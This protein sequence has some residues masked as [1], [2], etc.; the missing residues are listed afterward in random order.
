MEVQLLVMQYDEQRDE[1]LD[2]AITA[3]EWRGRLHEFRF[4]SC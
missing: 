2:L 3:L 4:I 1:I